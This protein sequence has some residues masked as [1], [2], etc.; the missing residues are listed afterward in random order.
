MIIKTL[1][2]VGATLAI[3]ISRLILIKSFSTV[4]I[5]SSFILV[6]PLLYLGCIGKCL[7]SCVTGCVCVARIQNPV[8]ESV[9]EIGV[10]Y[11][12]QL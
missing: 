9:Q 1:S 6:R 2:V 8:W 11:C 10:A 4:S 5:F 3:V 7:H 12:V